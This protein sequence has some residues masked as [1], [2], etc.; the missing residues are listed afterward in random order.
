MSRFYFVMNVGLLLLLMMST[1]LFSVD[2]KH[3]IK[4]PGKKNSI[5]QAS[6]LENFR[7]RNGLLVVK[8]TCWKKIYKFWLC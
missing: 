2:D 1:M 5:L 7:T 8:I 4:V 3:L 6:F